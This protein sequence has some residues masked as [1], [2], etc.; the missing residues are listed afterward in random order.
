MIGSCISTSLQPR[1]HFFSP[2][3]RIFSW[4]LNDLRYSV[5]ENTSISSIPPRKEFVFTGKETPE[6]FFRDSL[7][8]LKSLY[9]RPFHDFVEETIYKSFFLSQ[10]E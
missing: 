1:F 7:S 6:V 8:T 10:S 9:V 2:T 4:D 5:P 3:G